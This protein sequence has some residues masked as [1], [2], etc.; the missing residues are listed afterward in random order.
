MSFRDT[1]TRDEAKDDVQYDD[2]AF[3][4]F[5]G[6][7]CLVII[8][9]LLYSIFRRIYTKEKLK[10]KKSY[11][12]CE[13]SYCKERI[14]KHYKKIKSKKINFWFYFMILLVIVFSYLFYLSYFEIVKHGNNFKSF[15]P[16]EI[17]EIERGSSDEVIKKAYRSL[18][19]K[20]HPDRNPNNLQAK[21]KFLLLVKAYESLTDEVAKNNFEKYGNPDG[22]GSMRLAVGLPSFV[23]NKKNHMPI[24]ILFLLIIIVIIPASVWFWFSNTSKYD[25]SGIIIENHKVFHE[26]LNENILLKQMPFVLGVAAEYSVLN[27]KNHEIEELNKLEKQFEEFY[28]KNFDRKRLTYGNKKAIALLYAYLNNRPITIPSLREDMNTILKD[29]PSLINSMYGMAVQ[30]TKLHE[31]VNKAYKNFGY[32]CIKTII[33]FSQQIHQKIPIKT[34]AYLQLPYFTEERHKNL[35]KKQKPVTLVNFIR[36]TPDQRKEVKYIL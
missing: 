34:T 15:D 25:E 20:Y 28:P 10:D 23:L 29:A 27:I 26:I 35:F 8:F 12:S 4:T 5:G 11:M 13:C 31:N 19:R 24:L 36:L 14:D 7:I 1:F 21:A 30:L 2:S 17:L 6:T 33:Q 16:F 32:H 18:S 22:P 3:Y 9:P